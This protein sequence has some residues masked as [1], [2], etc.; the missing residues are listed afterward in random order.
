M[1]LTV[2][3]PT[4]SALVL[5]GPAVAESISTVTLYDSGLA[6]VGLRLTGDDSSILQ[7]DLKDVDD[8][9]KSLI[10]RGEGLEGARISLP[11]ADHRPSPLDMSSGPDAV[12]EALVGQVVTIPARQLTGTILR[13]GDSVDCGEDRCG[14]VVT[15]MRPS[16]GA[17]VSVPITDSLEIIPQD[18]SAAEDLARSALRA[19]NVRMGTESL[20]IAIETSG[21]TG[22]VLASY[23]IASPVWSTSWRAETGADGKAAIEAWAVIRNATSTDWTDVEL[24]LSSGAPRAIAAD[25]Y[26]TR[27]GR[28]ETPEPLIGLARGKSRAVMAAADMETSAMSMPLASLPSAGTDVQEGLDARFRFHEPVDLAAGEVLSMPLVTADFDA[29]SLTVWTGGHG[30]DLTGNPDRLLA[31]TNTLPVR[32]PAGIM[33]IRDAASGFVGDSHVPMMAPGEVTDLAFGKEPMVEVRETVRSDVS[34]LDLR[35][36]AEGVLVEDLQIV[37]TI[38]RIEAQGDAHRAV[39]VR[40]P[41]MDGWDIRIDGAAPMPEQL[42]E[43]DD[44]NRAVE[45]SMKLA[46][47]EPARVTVRAESPENRLVPLRDVDSAMLIAWLERPNIEPA[48]A[49]WLDAALDVRQSQQ[50]FAAEQRDLIEER[51]TAARDQA[52]VAGLLAVLDGNTAEHGRFSGDIAA[53]EDRIR[54]IDARL[55]DI[56]TRMADLD[57]DLARLLI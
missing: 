18:R 1:K 39:T 40:H 20:D 29:R 45:K 7:V 8:V 54:D 38:Y 16:D 17:L 51:D 4:L 21:A 34:A 43:G 56:R 9:L 14:K 28:R 3:L 5:A 2:L 23:V 46:P 42:V 31:L 24:T 55:A 30:H 25:I 11:S 50:A 6:E 49:A 26:A 36:S 22:D 13:V 47:G 52:R 35:V 41:F 32:V 33:T 57:Q 15:V 44:G 12:L 53:Q 10:L 19:G 48:T 37:E 27:W